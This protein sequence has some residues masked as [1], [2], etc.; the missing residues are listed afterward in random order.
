MKRLSFLAKLKK[1]KRLMLVEPSHEIAD[2]YNI[3]A[4]DCLK[5]AKFLCIQKIY[6]NAII[7]AYYAMYNIVQKLFFICGIKCENHSAAIEL[8]LKLF[9][10]N[11]L[12][13]DLSMAKTQRIDRQYYVTEVTK[14]IKEE[15]VEHMIK[16]AET[17][18]IKINVYI[19]N[20]KNSDIKTIRENLLKIE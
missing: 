13:I 12:S 15:I 6:E 14:P 4:N 8:L 19:E 3:K 9:G 17:F 11:N 5:A 16:R 18:V 20:L 2:S 7:D 10:L 1:Q